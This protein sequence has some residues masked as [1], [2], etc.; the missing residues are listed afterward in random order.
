MIDPTINKELWDQ[1]SSIAK[2][3]MLMAGGTTGVLF[4]EKQGACGAIVLGAG[5][6]LE[7]EQLVK[8]FTMFRDRLNDMIQHTENGTFDHHHDGMTIIRDSQTGEYTD[9]DPPGFAS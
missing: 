2:V 1:V 8:T 6:K 7:R 3:A 9:V 4:L 5:D